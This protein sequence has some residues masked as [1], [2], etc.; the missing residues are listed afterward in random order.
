MP[1]RGPSLR[2]PLVFLEMEVK[3]I[4]F[5][6]SGLYFF[7]NICDWAKYL[8]FYDCLASPDPMVFQKL[9]IR[10]VWLSCQPA[11]SAPLETA[12]L[13]P[14]I[15][16]YLLCMGGSVYIYFVTLISVYIYF[17]SLLYHQYFTISLI[18]DEKLKTE[19]NKAIL[20][21]LAVAFVTDL[22]VP[23]DVSPLSSLY[24]NFY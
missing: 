16:L 3:I 18:R 19:V 21:V 8:P 11:F 7:L 5:S 4:V 12:C 17:V 9:L 6:F 15:C 24:F 13:V 14:W 20:R 10:I 1:L 2:I 23:I 22:P